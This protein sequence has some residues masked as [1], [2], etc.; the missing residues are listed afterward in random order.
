[1]KKVVALV[2]FAT[3]FWQLSGLVPFPATLVYP[4]LES[5]EVAINQMF[6]FDTRWSIL[7]G[8]ISGCLFFPNI[9]DSKGE[10][11]QTAGGAMGKQFVEPDTANDVLFKPGEEIVV[12]VEAEC[13]INLIEGIATIYEPV[14]FEKRFKVGEGTISME[15][16]IKNMARFGGADAE[17][18]RMLYKMEEILD[19]E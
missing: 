14:V 9:Y 10:R 15:D 18:T 16:K 5:E 3:V 19:V 6:M 1:M 7:P 12:R 8:T 11:V 2:L 4:S 13:G 17:T